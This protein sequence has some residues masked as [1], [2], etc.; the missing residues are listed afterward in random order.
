M[1]GIF[2]FITDNPIINEET[3]MLQQS[4]LNGQLRGPENSALLRIPNQTYTIYFGF[5]RLAINGLT[6]LSNQ[7]FFHEGIYLICNG[8]IY[9][10]KELFKQINIQPITESDCEIILHLYK[11]FGIAHTLQLLDGVFA[12][13]L[14]DSNLNKMYIGRDTYG[15]RPLYQ[16]TNS[17]STKMDYI[18]ASELKQF[19]PYVQNNYIQ[20]EN[21]KQ[22]QPCTYMELNLHH[23]SKQNMENIE[24]YSTFPYY[25]LTNYTFENENYNQELFQ[26]LKKAVYKRVITTDREIACLLSGGF[27]SSTIAALVQDIRVNQLGYS[28]KQL[29]TYS[30]GLEGSPDLYYA[31]LVSEHIQSTHYEII[32]TEEELFNHIPETIYAIGSYDTTTVRAS[33]P[34][35]LLCKYISTH[36][37]AKVIFNGDGSDELCG[38]YLYFNFAPNDIEFDR[39][40]KKLLRNIHYFDVLR[41]DASISSN[42]LEPRTPFLDREF[43]DYYLS[44]PSQYRF[45]TKWNQME[46]YILRNAIAAFQPSLLPECVLYRRKEAF[47]DGITNIQRSWYEIIQERIIQFYKKQNITT[48]P[49]MH[50]YQFLPPTDFE[51]Y[52]YRMIYSH[53]YSDLKCIP[54]Y[55]KANFIPNNDNPSAR[56]LMNY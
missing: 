49:N 4:F 28:P 29:E 50:I 19:I 37:K 48:L 15:I 27:D 17:N 47:S 41:S 1:C 32:V 42:G 30:I 51:N 2:C 53:A 38:S 31:R 34:N 36:S 20:T 35:H 21:V 12:F 24:R 45:H 43:T 25:K 10:Y 54:Y 14:Y 13:I 56:T 8:E 7:P 52:Y 33:T 55:W 3:K 5:H 46:K 18:F 26:L 16:S 6:S 44:I 39:E 22:F 11:M 40:T 9:N 23:Q